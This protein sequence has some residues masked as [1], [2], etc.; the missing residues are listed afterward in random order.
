MAGRIDFYVG[1]IGMN[2]ETGTHC[3]ILSTQSA[4]LYDVQ[5][6]GTGHRAGVSWENYSSNDQIR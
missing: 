6:I 2:D 4:W 5:F 1:D 3:V